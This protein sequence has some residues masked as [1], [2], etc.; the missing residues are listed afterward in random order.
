[1]AV[2]EHSIFPK[3][4]TL[5]E[6]QHQI[7]Y[8]HTSRTLMVRGGLTPVQRCSQCILQILSIRQCGFEA[9]QSDNTQ[10]FSVVAKY[11]WLTAT[12]HVS[13]FVDRSVVFDMSLKATWHACWGCL[14]LVLSGWDWHALGLREPLP[15]AF[16]CFAG[17]DLLPETSLL[18]GMPTEPR[19]LGTCHTFKLRVEPSSHNK[20][21]LCH[22][23]AWC[24]T[25]RIPR[26]RD[27][28]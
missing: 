2:K 24:G 21:S 26:A 11:L 7:V 5:L 17:L 12:D 13:W 1:M 28:S 25:R 18:K 27:L 8:C 6:P 23:Q 14:E 10:I 22:T 4:P 19:Y 20:K 9:R 16:T 15:K 3:A